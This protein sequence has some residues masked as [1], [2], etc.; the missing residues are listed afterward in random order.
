M[1]MNS[2]SMSM[3]MASS[4]ASG[5][6]TMATGMSSMDGMPMY[7]TAD[8]TMMMSMRN[9][10]MVFF[11]SAD[12]PLFSEEW[13]PTTQGQYAG[14]CIFLIVLAIAM[15]LLL[16][17]RTNLGAVVGA[18]RRRH[19]GAWSA[20]KRSD[21][22]DASS[23]RTPIRQARPRGPWRVNDALIYASIDTTIAGVGYL[24]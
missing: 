16:A 6:M 19:D 22:S 14:T 18:W 3:D 11:N 4:T 9:M 17:L 24:L 20:S 1:D 8:G 12:T 15:R 5:G 21:E 23:N 10:M 13:T 2:M 7:E